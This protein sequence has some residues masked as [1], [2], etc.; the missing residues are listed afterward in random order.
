[1]RS[2]GQS[3]D[4]AGVGR[5]ARVRKDVDSLYRH[6]GEDVRRIIRARVSCLDDADDVTQDAWLG[7]VRGVS[8]LRSMDQARGWLRRI[9]INA[10][11]MWRRRQRYRQCIPRIETTVAEQP[12]VDEYARLDVKRTLEALPFRHRIVL[13]WHDVYGHS[14]EEI[15]ALLGVVPTTSVR[16]LARARSSMRSQLEPMPRANVMMTRSD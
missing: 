8:G 10:T 6:Y 13:I 4:Q 9:A 7:V 12:R 15:A 11:L 16:R 14:H 2:D 3:G 1:M 5:S